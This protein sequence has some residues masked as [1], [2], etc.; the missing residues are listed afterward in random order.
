MGRG[1][2]IILISVVLIGAGAFALE[3]L[4]PSTIRVLAI[5]L[6]SL[7]ILLMTVG[8]VMRARAK[9]RRAASLSSDES[10]S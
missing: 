3:G 10:G 7:L 4:D 2:A 8:L 9:R 6:C 1:E 5:T